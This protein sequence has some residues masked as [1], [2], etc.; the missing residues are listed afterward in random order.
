MS[1]AYWERLGR[2][3]PG[4]KRKELAPIVEQIRELTEYE[5]RRRE[6]D[7]AVEILEAHRKDYE[8]LVAK[9]R[10]L[11][12]RAGKLFAEEGFASMWFHAADVQRAF[13]AVGFPT[14]SWD[15]RTVE[16]VDKAIRFLA[17][18]AKRNALGIQLMRMLPDFVKAE[19]YLDA[20]I[21]QHS[22]IVTA[23]EPEGPVG[24][25]LLEMFRHG[26]E[27]WADQR[28]REEDAPV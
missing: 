13:E 6:I 15:P 18:G 26:M 9:P 24:G 22:A 4:R 19:R 5:S 10:Q 12:E 14:T 25:F 23:E 21:I 27:E 11:A 28:E 3:L 20:W 2:L 7:A 8:K 17:D 16:T 1:P